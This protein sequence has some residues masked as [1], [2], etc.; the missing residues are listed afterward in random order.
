MQLLS[1]YIPKD[2]QLHFGTV[3]EQEM[4]EFGEQFKNHV[5]NTCIINPLLVNYNNVGCPA[6]LFILYIISRVSAK[7]L[8]HL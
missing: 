2:Y 4:S 1:G 7:C 8:N 3:L 6:V 5:V